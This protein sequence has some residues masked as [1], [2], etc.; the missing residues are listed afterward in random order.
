MMVVGMDG[1]EHAERALA[2]AIDEAKLRGARIHVVSAWHVPAT[3]Y[4]GPGVVP[5]ASVQIEETFRKAAENA[6]AA[7]VERVRDA[8][9]DADGN[10]VEGQAAD[11]LIDAAAQADL[12][13]VG[14]RG[15]GGFVGLLLGSV[16]G[17]CAHHARCPLVIVPSPPNE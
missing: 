13:V 10:V 14:S 7:A 11:A 16:S 8:G 17:Q 3:V 12:L 5:T 1:S 6:A 4:G 2:W 9:V 15:H